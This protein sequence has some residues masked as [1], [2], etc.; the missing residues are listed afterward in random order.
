VAQ[1]E[2]SSL[3]SGHQREK[4]VADL[5]AAELLEAYLVERTKFMF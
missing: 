1:N 5:F 2:S 4:T 3:K